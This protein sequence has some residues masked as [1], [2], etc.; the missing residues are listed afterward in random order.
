MPGRSGDGESA[1]GDR[2]GPLDHAAEFVATYATDEGARRVA[3]SLSPEVGDIDGD[4][5]RA[6]LSRDGATLTVDVRAADLAALRAGCTTWTTLL[7]VAERTA[8]V[9][10]RSGHGD[11]GGAGTGRGTTDER[12]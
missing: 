10:A 9:D 11:D 8:G 1:D 2:D 5:T 6:S 12:A 4:R 7:S 3:A